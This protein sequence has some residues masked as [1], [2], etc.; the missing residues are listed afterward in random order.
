M[1]KKKASKPQQQPL[2]PV[3]FLKERVRLAPIYK[4]Y[5]SKDFE[6]SSEGTIMVV[7]QHA[8]DKFTCGLYLVDRY[9][10]GVK[11]ASYRL[12][13]DGTE[14]D[15]FLDMFEDDFN[16]H[17][18]SYEE[19]HNWVWGAVGFA[20]DAG[21][22][23]CK[24][25][26]LAQ[27]VLSEDDDEVELIEFDFGD[28]DGKHCLLAESRL[29]AST[30]LPLM[31]KNL[32]KEFS[33]CLGPQ[34]MI[35]GPEDWDFEKN[36][37]RYDDNGLYDYEDI[38]EKDGVEYC[39]VHPEY[40]SQLN[41]KNT[42]IA[43]VISCSDSKLET[44]E[45]IDAFLSRDGLREDLEQYILYYIG[46]TNDT[47]FEA[48]PTIYNDD[49]Y[50]DPNLLQAVRLLGEIGDEKSLDVLLEGLRQYKEFYEFHFGDELE[51]AYIPSI[52]KLGADH[53]DTLMSFAKEPGLYD[54]AH[55]VVIEAVGQ[56]Y[57]DR[58]DLREDITGW[59]REI[60]TF[61]KDKLESGDNS[62]C[63]RTLMGFVVS[64]IMDINSDELLPLIKEL[65]EKDYLDKSMCGPY[66]EVE[67]E[68]NNRK[69]TGF[70]YETDIHKWFEWYKQAFD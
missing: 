64:T 48:D 38:A 56:I 15:E 7:R 52:Q 12:R 33:F 53:L 63:S 45:E 22:E 41:L 47:A 5:A 29:E 39:Q 34:D 26:E 40:P 28:K 50:F 18:I 25:F 16:P 36:C 30:Y 20:E 2:S 60:T 54:Y 8:G 11:D 1:G 67:S 68:I 65:Y 31:K 27:Y 4:C 59:L 46:K 37:P 35:H 19:A 17:F 51:N 70:F 55:D 62:H 69:G 44:P 42:D 10:L 61:F 13:L 21:I 24:E 57:W 58:E 3:R 23:P 49:R 9:C 14:F 66:T 32:G 6:T 43:E